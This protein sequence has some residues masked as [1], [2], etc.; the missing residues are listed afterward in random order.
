MVSDCQVWLDLSYR[1]SKLSVRNWQN[2]KFSPT[3]QCNLLTIGSIGLIQ[4]RTI[5]VFRKETKKIVKIQRWWRTHHYKKQ[6]QELVLS[7]SNDIK[8]TTL[9]QFLH[10]LDLRSE[11]FDQELELQTLKGQ[12]SL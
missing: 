1:K 2:P 4:V 6:F 5:E 10:L 3:Y 12:V 9:R 8:L 7:S 11:D